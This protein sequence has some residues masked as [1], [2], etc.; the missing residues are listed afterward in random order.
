[1]PITMHVDD[2]VEVWVAGNVGLMGSGHVGIA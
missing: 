1:M 2:K